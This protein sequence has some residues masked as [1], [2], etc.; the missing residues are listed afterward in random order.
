MAVFDGHGG[1]EASEMASTLLLDYFCLHVV[2]QSYKLIMAQNK[3][4]LPLSDYKTLQLE[5]LQEALLK[6]IHDIDLKFSQANMVTF[7]D[8]YFTALF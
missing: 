7:F 3:G 1:E 8:S 2:F 5:I 4:V 6:T